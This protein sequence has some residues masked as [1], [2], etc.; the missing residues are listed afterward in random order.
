[1]FFGDFQWKFDDFMR[2]SAR[3]RDF[4]QDSVIFFSDLGNSD[5]QLLQ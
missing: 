4:F 3:F 5:L 2:N 1:M